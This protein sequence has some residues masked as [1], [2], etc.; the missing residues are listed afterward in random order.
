MKSSVTTHRTTCDA[1]MTLPADQRHVN[2]YVVHPDDVA[3]AGAIRRMEELALGRAIDPFVVLSAAGR[4]GLPDA[5]VVGKE[6]EIAELTEIL[7]GVRV[8]DRVRLVGVHCANTDSEQAAELSQAIDAV[9][10]RLQESKAAHTTLTEVR[11]QAIEA[12]EFSPARRLFSNEAVANVVLIPHDRTSDLSA[13]RFVQGSNPERFESHVA[14][15][16]CSLMAGWATVTES[17]VDG[18]R[19]GASSGDSPQLFFARSIVRSMVFPP[20]PVD[21]IV[22]ENRPLPVPDG[23][24]PSPQPASTVR[25]VADR[26]FPSELKYVPSQAPDLRVGLGVKRASVEI[27]RRIVS[28]VRSLPQIFRDGI[29]RDLE[30]LQGDGLQEL[31]GRDAWLSI[32]FRDQQLDAESTPWSERVNAAV[33]ELEQRDDMPVLAQLPDEVWERL[34]TRPFG[35]ADGSGETEDARQATGES[36]YLVSDPYA[37]SVE[38]NATAEDTISNM[39]ST[40]DAA[41]TLP[42]PVANTSE[43]CDGDGSEDSDSAD[44]TTASAPTPTGMATELS[45]RESI[46]ARSNTTPPPGGLLGEITVAFSDQTRRADQRMHEMIGEIQR[47]AEESRAD[48]ESRRV[49]FYVQWMI[50]GGLLGALYA[51][52]VFTGFAKVTDLAWTGDRARF[53]LWMLAAIGIVSIATTIRWSS[54]QKRRGEVAG[55]GVSLVIASVLAFAGN[56]RFSEFVSDNI[57]QKFW[58]LWPVSVTVISIG[59]YT[60]LRTPREPGVWRS[61]LARFLGWGTGVFAA[62][63]VIVASSSYYSALQPLS[64]FTD[65]QTVEIVHWTDSQR[66]RALIIVVIVGLALAVAGLITIGIIWV[67]VEYRNRSRGARF[68][69][70]VDEAR[71]ASRARRRLQLLTVQWLGTAAAITRVMWRPLGTV[72][73]ATADSD[74]TYTADETLLK[75]QAATLEL[76]PRG[77]ELLLTRLRALLVEPGWLTAQYRRAA[78][79]FMAAE[80]SIIAADLHPDDWPTPQTCESAP[81]LDTVLD[82]TAEG[83]RWSF[84]R[85]LYDGVLDSALQEA[86]TDYS[87]SEVFATVLDTTQAASARSHVEKETS[88]PR[89]FFETLLPTGHQDLPKGLVSIAFTAT[90]ARRS[91]TPHVS[92]PQELIPKQLENCTKIGHMSTL[93]IAGA[94]ITAV[95]C[96]I[97]PPFNMTDVGSQADDDT[98]VPDVF[99]DDSDDL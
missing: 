90:D 82:G 61:A 5:R 24:F 53:V 81:N 73:S 95:R 17:P 54:D 44:E 46:Q 79:S 76:T 68:R 9:K 48:S 93:G 30:S 21:E 3:A 96:D 31:I 63:T 57:G 11:V 67:R 97:S 72:K 52:T 15:E 66:L 40:L 22:S 42:P 85:S 47:L 75:F 89:E 99:E 70:A 6:S 59:L 12:A 80:P 36:R 33:L 74:A 4:D 55:F 18:W 60:R 19:P 94:V 84:M 65:T 37:L 71:A 41:R 86:V 35:V 26:T 20:L 50:A 51:V 34:V 62:G 10:E 98:F 23:F 58:P 87:P 69:F 2:V 25:V 88:D 78:R 38:M 83:R 77:E 29:S 1:A 14:V 91:L 7:A 16:L 43:T 56:I 64:R 32:V 92:W 28:I 45:V 27:P 13:A 8:L 49:P 39:L